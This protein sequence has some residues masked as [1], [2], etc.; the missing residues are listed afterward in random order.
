VVGVR[1]VHLAR[2]RPGGADSPFS[3]D[4]AYL[5]LGARSA[6]EVGALG[7]EILSPVTLEKRPH[8]YGVDLIAAPMMGRRAACAALLRASPGATASN[9]TVVVAFLAEQSFTRRGLLAL[10]HDAGPFA[11][12]YLVD[13]ALATRV[14]ASAPFDSGLFGNLHPMMLASHYTGTPVESVSLGEARA[15]EERLRKTMEGPE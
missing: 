6:A 1:S 8:R 15:L 2:G 3:V 13:G 14:A 7:V 12:T 10:G 4:D 5:D 9:G 11:E